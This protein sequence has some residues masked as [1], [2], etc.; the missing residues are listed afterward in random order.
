MQ[1]LKKKLGG[2]ISDY[3]QNRLVSSRCIFSITGCIIV[4]LIENAPNVSFQKTSFIMSSFMW[5]LLSLNWAEGRKKRT[6]K[7]KVVFS[8]ITPDSLFQGE[9]HS[10]H[11]EGH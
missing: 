5:D 3:F 11:P 9:E 4:K 2:D 10:S 6:C 8:L 1:A 7:G